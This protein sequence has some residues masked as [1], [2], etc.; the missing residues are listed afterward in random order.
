MA[1]IADCVR[2]TDGMEVRRSRAVEGLH[3]LAYPLE[4]PQLAT[5]APPDVRRAQLVRPLPRSHIAGHG[6][7]LGHHCNVLCNYRM[8]FE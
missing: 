5:M 7:S 1:H 6:R 3:V 4:Q 2:P 8:C